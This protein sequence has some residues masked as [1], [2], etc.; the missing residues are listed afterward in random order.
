MAS[1]N[2][3]VLKGVEYSDQ[4][5]LFVDAAIK[6]GLELKNIFFPFSVKLLT[7]NG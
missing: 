1:F 5:G 3:K 2:D 4:S 6:V 7:K